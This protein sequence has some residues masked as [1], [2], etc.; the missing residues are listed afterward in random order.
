[1]G[2]LNKDNLKKTIYY[3]QK[4]GLKNTLYAVRERLQ[5][6]ATD[7]YTYVSVTEEVLNE[8]RAKVWDNPVCFSIVVPVYHTPEK[9]FREMVESVLEQ[10]YPYWQLVLADA[11][12]GAGDVE[13][14]CTGAGDVEESTIQAV[15][16]NN[17]PQFLKK[18]SADERICYI[19]LEANVGIA[20]NTNVAIEAAT[21]D[22]IALFDHD[23]LLTPDALYEMASCLEEA[24]NRGI[25]IQMIY[26]D[27]DKCNSE[28]M[29]FYEPHYKVDFNLDLLMTNNYICHFTAVKAE[30]MKELKLRGAFNGAQDFDLVLRVAGRLMKET[31]QVDEERGRATGEPKLPTWEKI[32]HVPKV[33]YH[34]R[35]HEASTAANPA[36]KRYAYEAGKRAVED[37][38]QSRGWNAKVSHL[39]HL[40][41]YRV[42]YNDDIFTIR[43]DVG[44][45]GGR[46]LDKKGRL[47]GGMMYE[48]G[49]VFEE[50]LPDGFSGY[51]NRA[52]LMQQAQSLDLRAFRLNPAC[53]ELFEQ[54]LGILYVERADEKRTSFVCENMDAQQI[55]EM[56]LKISKALREKGY[57][58]IW[59]PQWVER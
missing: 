53:K 12:A 44:A 21:G 35:C 57:C 56:S 2:K 15:K 1:M 24:R 3:F 50:G 4:N 54:V 22:Y 5:K 33:L 59:D 55:K 36:S 42:D 13:E 40:G 27:E 18:Y 38:V 10:T 20:E 19:P 23:D 49:K 16:K 41:F 31:S 47:C 11:G 48:D 32:A 58:L 52:A 28:A 30:L 17:I 51:V 9:Y 45:V 34:W 46:I 14:R 26:T 25:N 39:K 8:Q 6:K 7:D 37:F 29:H 43:P